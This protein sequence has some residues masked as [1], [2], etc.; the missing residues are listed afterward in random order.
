MSRRH[1]PG[2]MG[3]VETSAADRYGATV[4]EAAISQFKAIAKAGMEPESMMERDHYEMAKDH[5]IN[6]LW[7]VTRVT[8]D[9]FPNQRVKV[10]RFVR[11]W[12][13]DNFLSRFND[14]MWRKR[15]DIGIVR[16]IFANRGLTHCVF[17]MN[18]FM[19]EFVEEQ[20]SGWADF[21]IEHM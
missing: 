6:K 14:W 16:L 11:A 13:F 2:M 17:D 4:R 10:D 18:D 5:F 8:F 15:G 12:D 21:W 7:R 9:V 3:Y 20:T 1:N 19:N